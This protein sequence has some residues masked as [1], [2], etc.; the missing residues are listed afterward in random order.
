MER[1]LAADLV[2]RIPAERA[3]DPKY[4]SKSVYVQI[5]VC[6]RFGEISH[7]LGRSRSSLVAGI[8]EDWVADYDAGKIERP[9]KP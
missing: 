3:R 5:A 2:A 6:E 7:E 8:L 1:M 4:S 9:K